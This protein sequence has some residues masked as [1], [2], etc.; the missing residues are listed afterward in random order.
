MDQ[1]NHEKEMERLKAKIERY[2]EAI[3]SIKTENAAEDLQMRAKMDSIE[4]R[5]VAGEQR[6]QELTEIMEEGLFRFSTEI[7]KLK[8][9]VHEEQQDKGKNTTNV[10]HHS[11]Y[12]RTQSPVQLRN[13]SNRNTVFN[14]SQQNVPAFSHLRRMAE[15]TTVDMNKPSEK[16]ASRYQ[17][18]SL[19]DTKRTEEAVEPPLKKNSSVQQEEG[20]TT[21]ADQSKAITNPVPQKAKTVEPVYDANTNVTYPFW[22]K[23][24]KI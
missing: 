1:A 24:K 3:S 10:K 16:N 21:V 20:V 8:A 19:M 15:Q 4:K 22:K 13:G 6:L 2:R 23:F 11:A 18:P 17:V 5:I 12:E 9:M 7:E 14:T